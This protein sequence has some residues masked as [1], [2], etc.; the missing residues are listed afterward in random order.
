MTAPSRVEPIPRYKHRSNLFL[1]KKST[2]SVSAPAAFLSHSRNKSLHLGIK[3]HY[4]VPPFILMWDK[5]R[6]KEHKKTI[7]IACLKGNQFP[8]CNEHLWYLQLRG[9]AFSQHRKACAWEL[10][11]HPPIRGNPCP[12]HLPSVKYSIKAF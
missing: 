11:S 12:C 2:P 7:I 5:N 4:N 10:C 9:S 3:P 8:L 6:T 1:L